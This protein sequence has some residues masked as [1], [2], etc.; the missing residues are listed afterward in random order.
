MWWDGYSVIANYHLW[1]NFKGN[2]C[3]NESLAGRE[4]GTVG[5]WIWTAQV[6]YC[7]SPRLKANSYHVTVECMQNSKINPKHLLFT[8]KLNFNF[9]RFSFSCFLSQIS[10][11]TAVEEVLNTNGSHLSDTDTFPQTFG[12]KHHS[13]LLLADQLTEL[14]RV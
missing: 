10:W 14:Y 5:L 8:P 9:Y 2:C 1:N 3:A 12:N 6:I 7:T 11:A 4:I 13:I